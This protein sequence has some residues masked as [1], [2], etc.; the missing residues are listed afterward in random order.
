[1]D[2]FYHKLADNISLYQISGFPDPNEK[3]DIEHS[4]IDD[5]ID[6]MNS[7]L[8]KKIFG[9]DIPE[10]DKSTVTKVLEKLSALQDQKI[11][12]RVEI[13]N[14]WRYLRLANKI[15]QFKI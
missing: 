3:A 2:G 7:H 15:Q 4:D 13:L 12:N 8:K 11:Q 10:K 14:K 9:V 5:S 1:M 6:F